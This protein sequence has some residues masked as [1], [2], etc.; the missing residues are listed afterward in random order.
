MLRL[1]R[2]TGRQLHWPA[3]RAPEAGPCWVR[4]RAYWQAEA[5]LRAA[6][7]ASDRDRDRGWA[8]TGSKQMTNPS[9]RATRMLQLFDDRFGSNTIPD[10]VQ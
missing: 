7:V 3:A 1:A 6:G 4:A 8:I 9:L 5:S 10:L 2:L